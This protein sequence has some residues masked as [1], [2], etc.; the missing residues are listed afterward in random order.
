MET[1]T[2]IVKTPEEMEKEAQRFVEAL[3]PEE[4]TATI[5]ALSGELGAGKTTFTQCVAKVLGIA[6]TV[7]SP[8]FVIEKIYGIP[9]DENKRF[10]RLVH[11]DAYRLSSASELPAL[12][13]GEL[14][15]HAGNLVMIEWPENVTGISEQASVHMMIEILPNGSRQIT[16]A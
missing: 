2:R 5:V 9:D 12:G 11:I 4:K 3:V 6:D 16:Y 1:L 13:F 14:T 15:S 8:T 10:K 7:N